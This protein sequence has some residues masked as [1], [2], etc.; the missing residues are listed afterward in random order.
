MCCRAA[1]SKNPQG[2]GVPSPFQIP[3]EPKA[4]VFKVSGSPGG[5]STAF[6][7]RVHARAIGHS[8]RQVTRSHSV[9]TK[10]VEWAKQVGDK[11]FHFQRINIGP[12][13]TLCFV[14]IILA[15]VVGNAVLLWQ[16]RWVWAQADRLSGVDQKLIVVLQAH[17]NLIS[18]YERLDALAHSEDTSRLVGE[19]KALHDALLENNRR[20]L[21]AL[22]RLP[23]EVQLDPALLPTLKA[24]QD[25]LPAHL[26]AITV[27]AKSGDWEAVRL[28]LANQ[29]RPL[30]SRSSALVENVERDVGNERAQAVLNIQQG[31]R[32]IFLIVPITAVLTLLFA[33]L[34]GLAIHRST[35]QPLGRLVEGS[36]ALARGDFSHRVPAAG[37]V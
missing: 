29:V 25:A 4:K 34:L 18:F 15:M 28:R 23:P 21:S 27:L 6:R 11:A 10:P 8:S 12:R 37:E 19:V 5:L 13:L 32:R 22:S 17:T 35:I 36:T 31:R 24:I 16:F 9:F 33:A 7:Y 1:A 2:H 26:E 20:S 14:L 30:E 3:F